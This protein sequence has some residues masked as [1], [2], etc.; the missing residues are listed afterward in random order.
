MCQF[1]CILNCLF[2]YIL[3]GDLMKGF[4]KKAFYILLP[5][6]IG[7]LSSIISGTG[8][9]LYEGIKQPPLSP[10]GYVFGI[11]WTILYLLIG[12]SYYIIKQS[13]YNSTQDADFWYY[14]QLIINFFW[15]IFFFR[16]EAF[17]FSF[18]WLLF[19]IYSVLMTWK[20][21]KNINKTS[22]YL[23]IPYLIWLVFAAYLNL[24]VAILN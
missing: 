17:T 1:F 16:A 12:I 9:G 6:F 4:L 3:L 2:E 21:F 7:L 20:K 11:A 23:L 18:I 15:P 22:S 19:L 5:L 13:S 24:G 8:N 14:L 10:P